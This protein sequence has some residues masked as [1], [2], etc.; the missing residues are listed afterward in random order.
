MVLKKA[1]ILNNTSFCWSGTFHEFPKAAAY[2]DT[3][4]PIVVKSSAARKTQ[5]EILIFY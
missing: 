1:I 5:I 4:P 2:W 3:V